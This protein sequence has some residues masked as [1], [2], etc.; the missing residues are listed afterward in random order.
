[1]IKMKLRR[2][3]LIIFLLYILIYLS[4]ETI[5]VYLKWPNT[6][7]FTLSMTVFTFFLIIYQER[8]RFN[9][10]TF[11][12]RNMMILKGIG[13][14]LALLTVEIILLASIV[15]ISRNNM[16][17]NQHTDILVDLIKQQKWYLC[18]LALVAPILEEMVFRES[19]YELLKGK[20]RITAMFATIIVAA[21]FSVIHQDKA[22]LGY[23]LVSLFLQWEY[24]HYQDIRYS[25]ITH[26]V[27]NT[28]SLIIIFLA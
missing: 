1:M 13:W 7:I 3:Y 11:T 26:G 4:S 20:N 2:N 18:Y 10:L 15:S 9:I 16:V 17:S 19:L 6:V 8:K 5:A 23:F 27:L 24:V 28:V 25:M 14:S 21:L 22:W 12:D